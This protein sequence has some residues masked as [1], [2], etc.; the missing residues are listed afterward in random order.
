MESEL[1]TPDTVKQ[2]R[3]YFEKTTSSQHGNQRSNKPVATTATVV[4]DLSKCQNNDKNVAQNNIESVMRKIRDQG[5]TVTY[6][7]GE[8][9]PNDN[10]YQIKKVATKNST[11]LKFE[12]DLK[13]FQN[14]SQVCNEIEFEPYEVQ[15]P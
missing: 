12:Y 7:G 8:I 3:N 4:A 11:D 2:V 9:V 13:K 15:Q 6:F 10:S 5:T 14:G 1:P